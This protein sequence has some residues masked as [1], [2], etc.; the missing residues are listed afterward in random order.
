[1]IQDALFLNIQTSSEK[2]HFQH[3]IKKEKR[4]NMT[5]KNQGI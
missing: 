4:A 2:A 5:K 3:D 1:M